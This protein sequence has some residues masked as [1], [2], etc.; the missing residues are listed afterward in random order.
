[1]RLGMDWESVVWRSHSLTHSLSLVSSTLTQRVKRCL[2]G[3][4]S[5]SGRWSDRDGLCP[6]LDPDHE[7]LSYSSVA[8]VLP[9][10]TSGILLL[11]PLAVHLLRPPSIRLSQQSSHTSQ[12]SLLCKMFLISIITIVVTFITTRQVERWCS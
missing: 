8:L 12:S 7:T 3:G 10:G 11:C 1:M 9:L 4:Q 5:D 2:T 6:H